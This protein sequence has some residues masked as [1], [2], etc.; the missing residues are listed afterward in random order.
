MAGRHSPERG[1]I[2]NQNKSTV[3]PPV[4]SAGTRKDWRLPVPPRSQK[5]AGLPGGCH[6]V[7]EKKPVAVQRTAWFPSRGANKTSTQ[8]VYSFPNLYAPQGG[9]YVPPTLESPQLYSASRP[10]FHGECAIISTVQHQH[11]QTA[12]TAL[13]LN[14]TLDYTTYLFC[15]IIN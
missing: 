15:V 7:E 14:R 8:C 6:F 11:G 9:L 4:C 13:K 2:S 12:A 10:V 3:S 5:A 1:R